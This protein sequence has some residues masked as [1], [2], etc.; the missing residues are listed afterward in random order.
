MPI[1]YISI[2]APNKK[3]FELYEL[4]DYFDY[5]YEL[6]DSNVHDFTNNLSLGIRMSRRFIVNHNVKEYNDIILTLSSLMKSGN[7]LIIANKNYFD[8]V[9]PGFMKDDWGTTGLESL[10]NN[11]NIIN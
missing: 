1:V 7:V 4:I 10:T 3:L 2:D 11:D 8:L 6:N 5:V 9:L